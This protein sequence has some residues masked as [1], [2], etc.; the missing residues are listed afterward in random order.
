MGTPGSSGCGGGEGLPAR[1][2]GIWIK[3][4]YHVL[5][6]SIDAGV[7]PEIWQPGSSMTVDK[8]VNVLLINGGMEM[9][10]VEQIWLTSCKPG[11][12]FT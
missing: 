4:A 10:C 8:G 6:S 9:I 5:F 1:A 12:D 3:P 2:H 11:L 7:G